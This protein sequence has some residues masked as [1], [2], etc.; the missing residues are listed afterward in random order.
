MGI[1]GMALSSLM[2]IIGIVLLAIA[3]F[4]NV[5]KKDATMTAGWI[6]LAI[7]L[8]LIF[9]V[10]DRDTSVGEAL[11]IA[12]SAEEVDAEIVAVSGCPE[13]KVGVTINDKNIEKPG[14]NPASTGVYLT[15]GPQT[16]NKSANSE[17][18]LATGASFEALVGYGHT[19]YYARPISFTTGCS[20][21]EVVVKLAQSGSLTATV[22]N[23]DGVSKNADGTNQTI[24]AND[25]REV[26]LSL[27]V[28]F[29]K[30]WGGIDENGNALGCSIA[31]TSFDETY[32]D[33]VSIEGAKTTGIP[34]VFAST[35]TA[36]D[37]QE[38]FLLDSLVDG[39][40]AIYSVKLDST[41]TDPDANSGHVVIHLFDCGYDIDED[42][43]TIIA[44]VEDE[45]NNALSQQPKNVT[46]FV[47]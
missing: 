23:D 8:V 19:S 35:S 24:D 36:L 18:N 11:A 37:G 46:I 26:E 12:P 2:V 40:K 43:E 25:E 14:T 15:S 21:Q 42:D 16:G 9:L 31:V 41:S 7:G 17:N 5:K 28:G 32:F 1:A 29:D 6:V 39:E 45:S 10:P 27:D 47:A 13:A 44:N 30:Y 4:G 33:E 22:I 38:A 3:M 34:S 20:N